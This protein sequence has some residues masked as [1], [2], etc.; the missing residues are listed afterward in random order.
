[1]TCHEAIKWLFSVA[2]RYAFG[3]T[4]ENAVGINAGGVLSFALYG[5]CEAGSVA[6]SYLLGCW[7]P[8]STALSVTTRT[9]SL[10]TCKNPP[11]IRNRPALPP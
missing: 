3:S 4:N 1:M 6:L 11:S 7:P 2:N 10:R 9:E 5:I 8:F